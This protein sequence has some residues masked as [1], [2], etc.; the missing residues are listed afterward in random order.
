MSILQRLSFADFHRARC[1]SSEWYS[2]SKSCI[3]TTPWI[4]TIPY[5]YSKNSNNDSSCKLFDPRDNSCYTLRD[6]GIDMATSRCLAS[7]G[8]WFLLLDHNLDFHLLNLFTRERILP[9]LESID[10]FPMDL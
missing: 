3:T 7:S 1:V 6:L 4:I 5:K 10:G 2:A 8:R 9:T